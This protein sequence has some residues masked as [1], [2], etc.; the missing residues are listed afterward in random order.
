MQL[1]AISTLIAGLAATADAFTFT[2]LTDFSAEF[3][4][5][6]KLLVKWQP[7]TQKNNQLVVSL[8]VY[9]NTLAYEPPN[10]IF[11]TPGFYYNDERVNELGVA[12][13]KGGKLTWPIEPADDGWVGD[14]F[15]Y[16]FQVTWN[17]YDTAADASTSPVFHIN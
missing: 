5:G 10:E 12:S 6:S 14:G 11:G 16:T 4:T 13:L 15:N 2:W 3:N 17:D 9:N 1:L 7:V 8:V